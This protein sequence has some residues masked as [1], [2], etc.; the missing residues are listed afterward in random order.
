MHAARSSRLRGGGP[1]NHP[2]QGRRRSGRDQALRGVRK[3]AGRRHRR[4]APGPCGRPAQACPAQAGDQRP[5]HPPPEPEGQAFQHPRR[6]ADPG[7]RAR[8]AGHERRLLCRE[9]GR[10]C[11]DAG[12]LRRAGCRWRLH[13][14]G[15]RSRHLDQRRGRGCGGRVRRHAERQ[16]GRCRPK[17]WWCGHRR[18]RE[19]Q[20]AERGAQGHREDCRSGLEGFHCRQDL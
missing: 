9:R 16:V 8:H 10:R 7:R 13:R 1:G 6:A 3:E 19:G 15:W 20:A 2:G 12:C 5:P 17:R 4:R 14:L 18:G 11:E